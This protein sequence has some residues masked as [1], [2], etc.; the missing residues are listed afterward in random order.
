MQR[1][2]LGV[3]VL[4]LVVIPADAPAGENKVY[5][6]ITRWNKSNTTD[7]ITSNSSQ[8]KP[9]D[10]TFE[11]QMFYIPRSALSGTRPIYRNYHP[12]ITDHMDST[13]KGEGGY[14]FEFRHG[15]AFK[16][17]GLGMDP[18]RRWFKLS[19]N[20]H[21]LSFEG[22]TPGGYAAEGNLGYAYARYGNS[23]EI[24]LTASA[25]G[26]KMKANVVSGGSI[27]ELWW[28]GKQ[29]INNY[30]YGRQISIATNLEP[31]GEK[32]NPTEGGSKYGCPG[33]KAAGRAQ[34]SPLLWS[35][36]R[37]SRLET[38]TAPLQWKP[39]NFGGDADSPAIWD[40][41]ISKK[42][43]L[44]YG[45]Y[46]NRIKWTTEIDFPRSRSHMDAEIATAY[47]RGEFTKFY[48]W[49]YDNATGQGTLKAKFPPRGSCMEGG[50]LRPTS[51]T[52]GVII[53]NPSGSH[54]LGAYR[55]AGNKTRFA[56]CDF[57]YGGSGKY[58][59]GTSKWAVMAKRNPGAGISAG[60]HTWDLYLVVG[61]LSKVVSEMEAMADT[62][63][64]N[65]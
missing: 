7:H 11:G 53:A 3:L 22:E 58:S 33:V 6:M 38:V 4:L 45:G 16:K 25:G 9:K 37:G 54:A 52:G 62:G 18:I 59:N 56:L 1:H 10:S 57:L 48:A 65:R 21:M 31:I 14:N 60:L 46:P 44:K 30:D 8:E 63:W 43:R 20:D 12:G 23:C 28:G 41:T 17:R 19:L 36:I 39:E 50:D 26:V 35:Y 24:L 2:V 15:Y 64:T 5:T 49:V 61:S 13:L 47:L 42:V 51:G 40:G 27:A 34:G 29:F 55:S 32:D